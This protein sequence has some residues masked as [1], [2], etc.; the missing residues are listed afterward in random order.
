ML[1]LIPEDRREAVRRAL[2]EAF[3][4]DGAE[5]VEP[6]GGG[7]SQSMVFKLHARGAPYLLKLDSAAG[8]ADVARAHACMAAAAQ[9]GIAPPLRYADPAAGV[10]IADFIAQRPLAERLT[11]RSAFLE[12]LAALVRRLHAVEGFPPAME[13]FTA[14]DQ[15]TQRLQVLD[16][17]DPAAI[18]PHLA[19]YAQVRDACRR[20][21]PALVA[22]HND[23]HPRNLVFDGTR[24]WIVDWDTAFLNDPFVDLAVPANYLA[25]DEAEETAFYAACLGRPPEPEE[26]ARLWL[27]RQAAHVCHGAVLMTLG[28][29]GRD[30]AAPPLAG[31]RMAIAEGRLSLGD[32]DQ[33]V[34]FGKAMMNE[35]LANSRGPRFAEALR[36]L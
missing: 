1:D 24:L 16:V 7:L 22:S 4:R 3:G 25:R 34:L 12:E 27:M 9:A 11:D 5:G 19:V 14:L 8:G 26:R 2:A 31:M 23:L 10:A 35:A 20:D 13:Y 21:A 33:R 6:L 28:P 32:P 15:L 17:V 18:A 30:M 36:L 29:G